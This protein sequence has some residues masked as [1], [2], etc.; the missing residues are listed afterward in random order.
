[1]NE[2][3][4]IFKKPF[5]EQYTLTIASEVNAIDT[6]ISSTI[7]LRYDFQVLKIEE[8]HI[9]VR[10]LVLDNKIIAANS[11]LVQEVANVSQVFGRMYN[12]LH[13]IL[14]LDGKVKEVLNTHLILS[15]WMETKKEMQ[16]HIAGNP[17]ME[18][19]ISLNDTIFTDPEKVKL[20]VQANE[21]FMVYFGQVF[22][23]K[24]PIVK[25]V[26]GTNIFS[27]ANMDWSVTIKELPTSS[28]TK[29][30]CVISTA[31]P[32]NGYT[33]GFIN[34]A[35]FQFKEKIKIQPQNIKMEQIEERYFE[36]ETGKLKKGAVKKEEIVDSVSLYQ[37]FSYK[38]ISDSEREFHIEN[39]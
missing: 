37:K 23:E 6:S 33:D 2:K 7:E 31:F 8:S 3:K 24:L 4:I 17:D 34:A 30:I 32:K 5:R 11:P 20:A 38:M 1:M 12:E 39:N 14:S 15:K 21:F 18:Q 25:S 27:T 13:L 36:L 19:V 26:H 35:Y 29:D 9:E 10:L 22:N 28:T 16:K